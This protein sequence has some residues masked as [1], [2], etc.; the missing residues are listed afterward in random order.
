MLTDDQVSVLRT[1]LGP[2]EIRVM[3]IIWENG[4]VT[5]QQ[6][7]DELNQE[8]RDYAYTTIMTV[9]SRLANKGLLHREP[10]GRFYTYKPVFDPDELMTHFS[11]KAVEEVLKDFGELAIAQFVGTVGSN[12][13]YL[14]KLKLFIDRLDQGTEP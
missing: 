13:D 5:V 2:L 8:H 1:T 4:D 11:S 7:L 12:P 9:M 10:S 6:V 14:K 3:E